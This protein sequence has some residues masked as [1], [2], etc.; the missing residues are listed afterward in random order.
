MCQI[1]G[2]VMLKV[3]GATGE[4]ASLNVSALRS[5]ALICIVETRSTAAGVAMINDLA[6]GIILI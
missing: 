5:T 6:K 3:A 2:K 4:M 1:V